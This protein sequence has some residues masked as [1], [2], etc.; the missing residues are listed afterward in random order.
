MKII[1]KKN[2][3]IKILEH[4]KNIGFVPTMGSIHLGHI[5]LIKK[6]LQNC[7]KTVVSIFINKPQFNQKK[8]FTNYPRLLKKDIILLKKNK[9][10]I[11]YLPNNKQIY[12]NGYK[13]LIR[14]NKLENKLCGKFRPGHFRAV[15]EVINRFIKIINPKYIYLGEKDMQQLKIIEDFV[16]KNFSKIKV[17][18]CKTKREKSGM[19][20]SSRNFLLNKTEKVIGSNIYKYLLKNKKKILSKNISIELAKNKVLLLGAKKIEYLSMIDVN[21]MIKPFK[22]INKYKIFISY[23]IGKVRLIDNI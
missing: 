9:V 10:N 1:S 15:V 7:D 5:S 8:D 14:V 20:L 17:I 2:E 6:S 18:S 3:L 11:L 4:E 19:A 22:K 21:K 23:Y 16:R 13:N 12:P